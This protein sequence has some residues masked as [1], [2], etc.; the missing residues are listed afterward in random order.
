MVEKQ[1]DSDVE[2]EPEE[3]VNFISHKTT[4]Q[5]L[6][7][8]ITWLHCQPEATPYNTGVLLSL[9]EIA[10]KKMSHN[11]CHFFKIRR[12]KCINQENG[13]CSFQG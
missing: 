8:C 3:D 1:I 2:D 5:M 4:M 9:K 7:K 11:S 13:L 6:D 12:S 10:A